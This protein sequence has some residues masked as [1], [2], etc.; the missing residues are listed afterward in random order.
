MSKSFWLLSA[1]LTALATPGLCAGR[2]PPRHRQRHRDAAVQTPTRPA[3][4]RRHRPGPPP[5]PPGRSARGH[6]G[7]RR[8]SSRTAAPT[9]SAS[10]TS[11]RRRCS[12]PRP[13]P[14]RTARPVSAASA[15]S[16]TIPASKA[17]SR[18]SSTASTA[19][20]RGI[21]LNEL[22][23]VERIEVLRGPQGTLFG[24]NASAGLIHIITRRPEFDDFGG[25]AELTYGNYNQIRAAGAHHRPA[26]RAARLPPRRGLRAAATASIDVVNP[27][28]GTEA[29]STTATASSSRGQLLFEP[30]DALSFRLIGDYT[31]SQRILLRRRLSR[32]RDNPSIGDLND[33]ANPLLVGGVTDP[34]GNNIINVLRD[35]GQPLAGF[36]NPY[37]RDDL[38]QPG[39]H[40]STATPR[41]GAS[42]SRSNWDLGG[43][44]L[45]S[46][47]AYRDYKSGQPGDIDY[48]TVDIL[49][50]ADAGRGPPVPDLQPGTAAAGHGLQR[51]SRLAGRRLFRRRGSDAQRQSALRQP[52]WRASRPAASF[53]AAGSPALY[54]PDLARLLSPA[55]PGRASAPPRPG[56]LRRLRP[57]R[58]DQRSRQ[59]ARRLFPEQPQLCVL[60]AQHLPH[61]RPAWISPLG[62]RYTN[63]RK[64]FAATFGND[65][66]RLPGAAGGA[67][68]RSSAIRRSRRV[69]RRPDRR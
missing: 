34:D 63:E 61:H 25:Y 39:P 57:A 69:A 22:G 1:G 44:T 11:S 30:N 28:G 13:A 58:R 60:H 29:G 67:R 2:A 24:R 54:S 23:E 6:R 7:R 41:T 50:R 47:T 64:R 36:S 8:A 52:I 65:N 5:D 15:R 68:R 32:P 17:R 4:H 48:S 18:C 38:R 21:G 55:R 16:A 31:Q 35:L 62:L 27:T 40:L 59:H 14:K 51:P 10:S 3:R 56:H 53:R 43:A 49:Y 66:T 46:I 9:T 42:R 45:T 19:R 33:P 12:S 26:Q 20:A 37:S